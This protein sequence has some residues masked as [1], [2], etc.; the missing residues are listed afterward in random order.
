MI[1]ACLMRKANLK[2]SVPPWKIQQLTPMH[3][4]LEERDRNTTSVTQRSRR[5]QSLKAD[6]TLDSRHYVTSL[7][8]RVQIHTP[9]VQRKAQK[10][11]CKHS[12]QMLMSLVH[13]VHSHW[14]K[15]GQTH[16]GWPLTKAPH[17]WQMTP[18]YQKEGKPILKLL[19]VPVI[20]ATLYKPKMLPK[21]T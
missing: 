20:N 8:F 19:F 1:K 10:R 18:V 6:K 14:E 12:T 15:Q 11:C 17:C 13:L 16:R 4:A 21:E 9:A 5:T 2:P 3:Q 7:N